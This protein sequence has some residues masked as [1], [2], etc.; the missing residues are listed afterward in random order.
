M[1]RS[2]RAPA[3]LCAALTGAL[4]LSC[5][6]G[7]PDDA[8]TATDSIVVVDAEGRRIEL[9]APATRIVSLVPSA[10]QTLHAIGAA[11]ALAGR[12][13]FDTQPWA[14]DIPS[15]GGGLEPSLE[16][17]VALEPDLVIRFGG[18]QDPRT[19][20]RLEALRIP[21]VTIRPD[22]LEDVFAIAELLGR[23]TGREEAAAALIAEL[24]AGLERLAAQAADLPRLRV[25]HVLGGSPPWVTGPGTYIDEVLGL[26]GGD[27]VF[28]D[29]G[30]LYAA[31]S[32][33]ELR[34]RRID[35]VLV[36]RRGDFDASL[37]PGARV[38]EIG[39]ALELPG[40]DVVASARRVAE[41][42]HGRALR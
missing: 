17:L 15:V 33:E 12:T 24:R 11:G 22:R 20:G 21:Y 16:A 2:P 36:P 19:R 30:A 8:R 13:D 32:P 27:N 39:D 29:L 31:V 4:S 10:T 28:D 9:A 3:V 34:T 14:A 38:V 35:V 42:M 23:A 26:I 40:P 41:L 1:R 37:T 18:D 7:A 25:A 5:A 6:P